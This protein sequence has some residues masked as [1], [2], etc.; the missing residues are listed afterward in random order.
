MLTD[1]RTALASTL[2]LNLCGP[3]K[4][5]N[6]GIIGTGIQARYQGDVLSQLSKYKNCK[7]IL[8]GR[9]S[10]NRDQCK[11]YLEKKGFKVDIG[12]IQD[13]VNKCN[14]ISKL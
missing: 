8:Y 6:I 2:A 3:K 1:L 4:I 5:T 14:V 12:S 7:I 11:L 9:T 10:S 13:I